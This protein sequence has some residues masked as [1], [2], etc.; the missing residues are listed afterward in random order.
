MP[1]ADDYKICFITKRVLL[2]VKATK[3]VQIHLNYFSHRFPI[4][5]Y[6]VLY[7]SMTSAILIVTKFLCEKSKFVEVTFW[8]FCIEPHVYVGLSWDV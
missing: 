5:P 1:D 7:I 3:S 4:M 2:Q 8:K 6:N